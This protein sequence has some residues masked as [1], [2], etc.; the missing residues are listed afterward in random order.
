MI[1]RDD[2][3]ETPDWVYPAEPVVAYTIPPNIVLGTE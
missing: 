2:L 1:V 3:P